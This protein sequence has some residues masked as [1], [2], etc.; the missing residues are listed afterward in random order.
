[1]E[2]TCKK[3][4]TYSAVTVTCPRGLVLRDCLGTIR[5]IW[6]DLWV[7]SIDNQELVRRRL[8]AGKKK[9]EQV[10]RTMNR[11]TLLLSSG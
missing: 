8:Q 10:A 11:R 9:E 4:L 5:P 6:V 2:I 7:L 1:M 3:P